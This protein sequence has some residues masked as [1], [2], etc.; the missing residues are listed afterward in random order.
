M[1]VEDPNAIVGWQTY[2]DLYCI[3]QAG[4]IEKHQLIKF[5]MKFFN[6]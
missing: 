6:K 1:D 4:K 3:F 5:W 2:L